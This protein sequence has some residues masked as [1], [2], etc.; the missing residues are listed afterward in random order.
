MHINRRRTVM[1]IAISLMGVI[2]FGFAYHTIA[3]RAN[4]GSSL[5]YSAVAGY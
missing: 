3:A 5:N 2:A 4:G 1:L